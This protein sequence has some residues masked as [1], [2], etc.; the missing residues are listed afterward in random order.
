MYLQIISSFGVLDHL[1]FDAIPYTY[2]GTND[3]SDQRPFGPTTL[4]T[5]DLTP[6]IYIVARATSNACLKNL[7]VP[8]LITNP[9][10]AYKYINRKV[11]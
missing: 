6:N 9:H 11:R 4:R 3:L 10:Y 1:P 5:N 2:F 7:N 8:G